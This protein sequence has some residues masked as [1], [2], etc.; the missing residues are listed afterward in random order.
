M[1]PGAQ[2]RPWRRAAS[3]TT[4]KVEADALHLIGDIAAS[5]E[6]PAFEDAVQHYG[7]ALAVADELGM[8][9]LV[10]HCHLGLGKL[11][12]RTGQREQARE[13]LS[14]ATAMYSDMDM[15]F[16]LAQTETELRELR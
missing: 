11:Y 9:P 2:E 12:R 5:R 8:R 10:A 7:Q 14:A 4:R 16:W 13:H 3:G 1:P 15:P 6:V